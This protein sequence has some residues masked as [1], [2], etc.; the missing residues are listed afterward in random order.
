MSRSWRS[1]RADFIAIAAGISAA[2][3]AGVAGSAAVVDVNTTTEAAIRG[4]ATVAA[5][6]NVL[7]AATDTTVAYDIAGAV[8]LGFGGAGGAGAV[9]V[10]LITK[11]TNALIE[12]NATVDADG[13]GP[14][15]LG[16]AATGTLTAAG[17]QLQAIR[18]VA[19]QAF[20]SETITGV[21]GSGAGGLYAGVAGGVTVEEINAGALAAIRNG[22][23]VDQND[24]AT[25]NS[26]QSVAV[27]ARDSLTIVA[28]AGALGVG[29]VGVG[30]GI[31]VEDLNNSTTAFIADASVRAA[32][33]VAVDALSR[34]NISRPPSR[35]APARSDSAAASRC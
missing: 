19:V 5:G 8:G 17:Y 18:G 31:D 35:S 23:A 9:A 25:A 12:N 28:V 4:F 22:A 29:G 2:G 16:G 32:N 6:G 3:T 10:S 7:V 30:A 27:G 11:T 24:A 21:A 33:A 34:Q 1:R 13:N 14:N 20:S 26:Q 15:L